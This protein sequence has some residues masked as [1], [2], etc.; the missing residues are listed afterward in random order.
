VVNLVEPRPDIAL[1]GAARSGKDAVADYLVA[2]YG[3]VK[4]GFADPVKDVALSIDP[5]I[6][7]ADDLIDWGNEDLRLSEYVK[8]YGWE[9]AKDNHPE[10]RRFLV[11]LGHG[12]R[13]KD[14]EVW[15]RIALGAVA[16]YRTAGR[17]VVISGC[18]YENEYY[19]LA[20]AGFQMVRVH[21]E[22]AQAVGVDPDHPSESEGRRLHANLDIHNDGSLD[23]LYRTIDHHTAA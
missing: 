7:A 1:M 13:Q 4:I 17:P 11:G 12:M 9:A 15:L 16:E 5:I 18:R 19:A 20:A 23:D 2:T 3:Y 8:A 14:P 10:V 22:A 21:R 6:C